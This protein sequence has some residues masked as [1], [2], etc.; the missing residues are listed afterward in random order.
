MT[1]AMKPM[2]FAVAQSSG[3]F[4]HGASM[5]QENARLRADRVAFASAVTRELNA[6]NA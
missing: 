3:E 5:E 6:V 2:R 1:R 4:A